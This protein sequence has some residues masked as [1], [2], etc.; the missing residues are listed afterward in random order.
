M[1]SKSITASYETMS[2]FLI[3]LEIMRLLDYKEEWWFSLSSNDL[4]AI[5]V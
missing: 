3:S 1:E 4:V 2:M 5:D